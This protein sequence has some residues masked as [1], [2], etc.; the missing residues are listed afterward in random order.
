MSEIDKNRKFLRIIG[1]VEDELIADIC[2]PM[3][4]PLSALFTLVDTK[5]LGLV[6]VGGKRKK[7]R[8]YQLLS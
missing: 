6:S 2:L 7:L 1:S 4:A 3:P 5:Y 8:N